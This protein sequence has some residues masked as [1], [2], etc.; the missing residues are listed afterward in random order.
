MQATSV[1]IKLKN[2]EIT[3]SAI[4]CPPR[5]LI[6]KDQYLSF[7]KEQGQR[8]SIGGDFNAKYTF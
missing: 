2:F 8:F 4:Y 5:Y 6:K 7:L 3:V 1:C